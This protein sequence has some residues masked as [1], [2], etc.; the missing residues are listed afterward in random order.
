MIRVLVYLGEGQD[1]QLAEIR[2]SNQGEE[3]MRRGMSAY[4]AEVAVDDAE[5]MRL[6]TVMIEFPR[7][8][9]NVLALVREVLNTLSSDQLLLKGPISGDKTDSPD[10]ARGFGRKVQ[11]VQRWKD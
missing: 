1:V 6:M 8:E 5:N 11:E 4:H 7:T 10:M 3:G 2:I 9:G